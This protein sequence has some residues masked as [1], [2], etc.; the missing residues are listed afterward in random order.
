MTRTMPT[1][2]QGAHEVLDEVKLLRKRLCITEPIAV[3]WRSSGGA[4]ARASTRLGRRISFGRPAVLGHDKHP[5]YR[6]AVVSHEVLH[7]AVHL[8]DSTR[9]TFAHGRAFCIHETELLMEYGVLPLYGSSLCYIVGYY[10]AASG[11][12][13]CGKFGGMSTHNDLVPSAAIRL[14]HAMRMIEHIGFTYMRGVR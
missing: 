8:S 12:F 4:T 13:L 1:F 7:H 9:L 3:K 14:Q 10:D 5:A 2:D 6:A 11:E